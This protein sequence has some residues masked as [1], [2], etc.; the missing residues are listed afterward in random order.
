M[1]CVNFWKISLTLSVTN[2]MMLFIGAVGTVM[3]P[4]LRRTNEKR[5]ASIYVTMR[6]F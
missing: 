2:L 5:L 6:D 1:G 4:I 3:F